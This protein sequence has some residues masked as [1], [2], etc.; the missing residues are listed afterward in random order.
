[1]HTNTRNKSFQNIFNIS[2]NVFEAPKASQIQTHT[3]LRIER[4]S[5]SK[6]KK[7]IFLF[8][9]LTFS[10]SYLIMYEDPK[11]NRNI[12]KCKRDSEYLNT[13]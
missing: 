9:Y 13:L 6:I 2:I 11:N 5:K 12:L 10:S 4:Q 1:M 3:Y 8:F 7:S